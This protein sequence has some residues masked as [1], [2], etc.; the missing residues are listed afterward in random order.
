ME[1]P[2]FSS[3]NADHSSFD[4]TPTE[5]TSKRGRK[6]KLTRLQM[7]QK[8]GHMT[9]D[10]ILRTIE[11]EDEGEDSTRLVEDLPSDVLRTNSDGT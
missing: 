1:A 9:V 2:L 3:S 10:D 6:K 7:E 5:A 8:K 4:E 11:V